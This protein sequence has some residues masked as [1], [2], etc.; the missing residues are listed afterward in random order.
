MFENKHVFVSGGRTGFLGFNIAKTLLERKAVVYAHSLRPEKPGFFPA[1]TPNVVELSG[2]LS[3]AASLPPRT[4]Y[5]FHCAA[6]TSGAYE[7]VHNPVA[8]ITSNLFMNTLLM[9]SAAKAGVK[10][11]LFISSSAV[12]PELEELISE[13]RAFEGDPPDSYFGPA[14]MKRYA[15]KL[16]QF[17]YKRYGMEVV[18]IRPSNAYG[19]Y[20]GFDLENSHVLPALIR[21]FVEKQDPIE[22]WGTPD[23]VRDFIYV[24]DFVQGALLAFERFSGYE[25]CN[26]ASGRQVTIGEAVETIKDLTGYRGKIIYN[27]SKPMTVGTRRIDTGKAE[28]LLGFRA[29]ITF[30]EGL[31]RTIDW[32]LGT[33]RRK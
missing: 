1:G 12:Y 28:R 9:D 32:Y 6:H 27:S 20:S 7:M 5:V 13:D 15:E 19:P 22:V 24:D 2:D 18:I 21:K 14:W 17:Y 31:R 29:A 25:I 4:E 8:Q 16:A 23:V 10:K 11:F 30:R 26:I 3:V 33:L